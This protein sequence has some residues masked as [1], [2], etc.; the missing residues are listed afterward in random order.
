[1]QNASRYK[2]ECLKLNRTPA[3][4]ISGCGCSCG[5]RNLCVSAF[6]QAIINMRETLRSIKTI[7]MSNQSREKFPQLYEASRRSEGHVCLSSSNFKIINKFVLKVIPFFLLALIAHESFFA[8]KTVARR[9]ACF[10]YND[11]VH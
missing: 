5:N 7:F 10:N 4:P 2:L 1:M 9:G 11:L 8:A 3:T 6:V